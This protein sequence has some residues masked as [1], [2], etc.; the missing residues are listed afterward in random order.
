MP[1]ILSYGKSAALKLDI[2]P[3]AL[4]AVCGAPEGS[5]DDPASALA[6]SLSEPVGYPVLAQA[7][8]PGDRVAIVLDGRVPRR[9][10]LL[11]ESIG[12]SGASLARDRARVLHGVPLDL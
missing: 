8:V 3:E 2:A 11:A 7:V 10:R 6:A 12:V 4:V 5:L 1:T 9:E